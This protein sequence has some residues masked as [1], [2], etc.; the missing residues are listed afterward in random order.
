MFGPEKGLRDHLK[1]LEFEY[2]CGTI[3]LSSNPDDS[4]V[5]H[6]YVWSML[7]KS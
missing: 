7:K 4:K 3:D 5:V 1:L 6:F 2:E